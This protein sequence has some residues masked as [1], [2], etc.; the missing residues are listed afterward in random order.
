MKK[1]YEVE[2]MTCTACASAIERQLSKVDGVSRVNVNFAS[3]KMVVEFNDTLVNE[4]QLSYEVKDIG[5]SLVTKEN[6]STE[7]KSKAQKH[8]EVMGF[9]L[10]LSLIFSIPLFYIAMG[11]MI[12]L[13]VPEFFSYHQNVLMVGIIQLLMT[14]PV[15]IVNSEYYR[16]GFKTLYKRSPNMDSLI[17][18]GTTAAFIYGI[19]V[20]FQLAYGYSYQNM[21]IV[22][23]YQHELYFESVVVILTLITLGKFLEA[24]AKGKTLKALEA[25]ME[26]A[27]ETGIILKEGAEVEMPVEEIYIGDTMIIKAG[28]KIALDGDII[29]GS[30][31][32]DESMLTGE[33]LPLNKTLNETIYAGTMCKSGFAK[34]SVTKTREETAL[35]GIVRLVEEAQST[36]APIA[37]MADT[38]SAYFVPAVLGISLVTF[39]TWLA[40]GEN[41]AFAFQMAVSVLVISCPCALG[42]ATPT[43]IMVG[44][45]KGASYGTLIK[46]GE[47]LEQLYKVNTIV[48]DK[49]GTL[50]IGKPVVTDITVNTDI[51]SEDSFI[52]LIASVE[53]LS[54]HPYADAINQYALSKELDLLDVV[55]YTTIAGKGVVGEIDKYK[56]VI[57]NQK[58]MLDY[59]IDI[60]I[61]H[62]QLNQVAKLGKTPLLVGINGEL[63][64]FVVVEDVIK[65]EAINIVRKLKAMKIHVVMLTGD[66]KKTAETIADSLGIDQVFAEVLPDGKADVID[67]LMKD[68]I[69]AMVGD[70]INDAVALTKAHV[71]VAIGT[72]TDV[73]IES[74]D[75]VLV[76]DSL[77][78]VITAI[79]LSKATIRN[80]K[81]NLFWA[82]F[83]N[84]VGI[85]FAAGIF[86]YGFGIKL[87]PMIAAAA[88]SFSSV[89]VVTNALRLKGFKPSGM[90]SIE[91]QD[92]D[93][94]VI[95]HQ[96]TKE[97]NITKIS[98]IQS[99][100]TNKSNNERKN[101]MKKLAING[102]TCMHCVGRVDK[103]LNGIEGVSEVK[104]NLEDNSATVVVGYAISDEVLTKV[105][106][107]AGYEV[108]GISEV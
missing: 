24:K 3:E 66:H 97:I 39:V 77:Q 7:D 33:S 78:D 41:V 58:L 87:N 102:M 62:E 2:G 89:S 84:M 86:Y 4:K 64:G 46:S 71:G 59:N 51:V 56:I 9:R 105:V 82:F 101:E 95:D 53:K 106:V 98:D 79:E 19:F 55:N 11:P 70:G 5:Y 10:V 65:D 18:V 44:T 50:T 32:L 49:T 37:K 76:K 80:I 61:L 91:T 90:K 25:L 104:V 26:L 27:P 81:Q 36:K 20:I 34:V 52:T 30:V 8:Q 45:G 88:M 48:F 15:M 60:E 43:A 67:L 75:V 14:I 93:I 99:N 31:L 35:F 73:A 38:I 29:E 17:A 85:P 6:T 40:L 22:M 57:G 13:W 63:A 68:S 108:V 54:E 47:A 107:D 16:V 1:Q 83:Y 12:G 21:E 96:T 100:K 42:L 72:G 103:A 28:N 69:V 92:K 23:L 94:Q 74:A